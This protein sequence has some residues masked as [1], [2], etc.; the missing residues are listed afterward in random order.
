MQPNMHKRAQV[1]MH[2][3]VHNAHAP[4]SRKHAPKFKKEYEAG[5][6]DGSHSGT[7]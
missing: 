2:P 4:V 6:T 1:N 7:K 5:N 3:G